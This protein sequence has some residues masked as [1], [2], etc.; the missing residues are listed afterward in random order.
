MLKKL[1]ST[2]RR[3]SYHPWCSHIHPFVFSPKNFIAPCLPSGLKVIDI[4]LK[5]ATEENLKGFG[6]IVHYTDEFTVEKG[7]F[8]I[9]RWP[10]SGWRTLDPDTGDEA[11][12]IEGHFDVNWKGDFYYG[13]NL[14]VATSN[15]YYLDGLSALPENATPEGLGCEDYIYLWMSDYHPDGAQMFWPE[16]P[17]P[18]V[19][20]LGLNTK[21]DDITPKDMQSFFVPAGLGIYMHPGTWHNG[22]Y[23]SKKD[24][25]A[26]FLTRQGRIHARVSISWAA[27]FDSILRVPLKPPRKLN[28]PMPDFVRDS[29]KNIF[30][31]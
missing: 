8:E 9:I 20:T 10:L 13:K 29:N 22:I 3:L 11:G 17:T 18:F 26:R 21:G 27:E 31:L 2:G 7:N 4:P 1:L 19:V 24:A 30:L 14:A 5:L 25:P 23:V 6:H 15:N 12:T 16:R 28:S